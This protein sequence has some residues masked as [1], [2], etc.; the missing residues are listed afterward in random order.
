MAQ[1]WRYFSGVGADPKNRH[2]KTISQA[3]KYDPGATYL[4]A[5]LPELAGCP[6]E[7]VFEPFDGRCAAWP[8]PLVA[9]ESQLTWQDA[10]ERS[11][12]APAVSG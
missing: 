12:V 5:W 6:D 10:A 8:K 3:L 7:H 4:R 2:F 1:N 11:E 9:P